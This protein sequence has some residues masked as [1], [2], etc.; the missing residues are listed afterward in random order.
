MAFLQLEFHNLLHKLNSSLKNYIPN[1]LAS[2]ILIYE[3][4]LYRVLPWDGR[5][6]PDIISSSNLM[7]I[8]HKKI[9]Y[10][11]GVWG[12]KLFEHQIAGRSLHE[13]GNCDNISLMW[14]YIVTKKCKGKIFADL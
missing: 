2:G 11:F 14:P 6:I 5:G 8:K 9:D 4:G 3:S 1:V 12:K 10:P 13:S 7:S